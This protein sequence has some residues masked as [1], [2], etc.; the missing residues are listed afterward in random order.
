MNDASP[1]NPSIDTPAGAAFH[2]DHFLG[3]LFFEPYAIEIAKRIDPSPVSIALEIAAGTGRVTRHI[4]ERLPASAKLIASDLSEEMLAEA[5]KKLNHLDITWQKIDAQQLPVFDNCVDLV[6]CCFGYMFV[7]D[8]QKAFAE[9]YR[10][11]KPGGVLLITTW[12]KL[13]HNAASYTSRQIAEK[14][15]KAP[16]PESYSEAVSMHDE[17][18]I[19]QLLANAGFSKIVIEK[20]EQF[21]VC[22][23]AKQA[24][25]GLVDG[26]FVFKEI[27]Q[28]NPEWIDEIKT[29][30]EKEL[31]EKFGAAPMIAPMSAVFS[32]AWK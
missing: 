32:Q 25:T 10:V 2:Y 14:Y 19:R 21:S 26:G 31:A 28:H 5:K 4:R 24:A 20:V 13:E 12:D 11:L 23:T 30:L 3:P 22:P 17:T 16:L 6:V 27:R 18:V 9:A 29:Q 1:K 8:K 7:P 15:L